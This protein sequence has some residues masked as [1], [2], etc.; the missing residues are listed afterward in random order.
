MT[1]SV[2][3]GTAAAAATPH[4]A[5]PAGAERR[6]LPVDPPLLVLVAGL[7]VLAAALLHESRGTVFFFDEWSVWGG[8]YGFSDL[9]QP[10]APING[11]LSAVPILIF[12]LLTKVFGAESHL[13]F[14]I[15]VVVFHAGFLGLLFLLARRRL[16]GWLAL[17][18]VAPLAVPA[19]GWLVLL[20]PFTGL[21]QIGPLIAVVAAVLALDRR[22]RWGDALAMTALLFLGTLTAGSGLAAL[23]AATVYLAVAEG[24]SRALLR[25]AWVVA[26]PALAYAAWSLH[27]NPDTQAD[28]A[29]LGYVAGYVAR[30]L[31]S[32][33][34]GYLT[35]ANWGP[36]VAVG[37]AA[38]VVLRAWR[39]RRVPA[40]LLAMLVGAVGY[41]SLIAL[42]RAPELGP[43]E[44]RYAYANI[45]LTLLVVLA[46]VPAV[47]ATRAQT[48]IAFALVVPIVFAQV[49][50]YRAEAEN[51]RNTSLMTNTDLFVLNTTRDRIDPGY[52]FPEGDPQLT[53]G[54]YLN[55]RRF[56][57]GPAGLSE[58]E[59]ADGP[60]SVQAR[61]DRILMDVLD[62]RLVP[63]DDP[64]VVPE[65]PP[66]PARQTD[67]RIEQRGQCRRVVP[68]AGSAQVTF[69]LPAPAGVIVRDAPEGGVHVRVARFQD[70]TA[71]SELGAV[72]PGDSRAI[73]FPADRSPRPWAVDLRSDGE[74]VVCG[75]RH[76]GP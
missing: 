55:A 70:V 39:A 69:E 42:A 64:R 21:F 1:S 15:S 30:G 22:T 59:V 6:R 53:P 57:G 18:V 20:M 49:N 25:R 4:A 32:G 8:R 31:D 50:V 74:F 3:S 37:I 36:T 45:A 66:E 51:Y 14:R 19:S 43:E 38:L 11:H 52:V 60:V 44:V 29:N 76:G 2:S 34:G 40:L 7:V 16:G 68:T 67:A 23:A 12:S 61:A 26:I 41:W 24:W 47:R 58:Q 9:D 54:Q 5:S 13:P 46:A 71:A 65:V 62:T 73:V 17:A 33:A 63:A 28:A 75:A 35:I 48:L 72:A 27:Y 10:F 56:W